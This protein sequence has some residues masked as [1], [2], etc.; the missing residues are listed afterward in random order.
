[1]MENKRT[2]TEEVHKQQRELISIIFD[3]VEK[4]RNEL[5]APYED[6]YRTL[7]F[8]YEWENYDSLAWYYILCEEYNHI[9]K[10][11]ENR[12]NVS[13]VDILDVLARKVYPISLPDPIWNI[14]VVL[15]MKE[16]TIIVRDLDSQ[17]ASTDN[18][19]FHQK[20]VLK[21]TI[22]KNKSKL[23]GKMS[24]YAGA[25]DELKKANELYLN[26]RD[27]INKDG[28]KKIFYMNVRDIFRS[29]TGEVDINKIATKP[30]DKTIRK[31][32]KAWESQC[33]KR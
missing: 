12:S 15:R 28:N 26:M 5:K 2:I 6:E 24:I 14:F 27:S 7:G 4:K 19:I 20:S 17:I 30:D 1:M 3:E 9:M 29:F 13:A 32:M 8:S 16:L 21:K 10:K 33:G 18:K 11:I 31:W 23:G 25:V 22:Y